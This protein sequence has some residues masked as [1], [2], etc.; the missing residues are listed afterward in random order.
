MLLWSIAIV[1]AK[2]FKETGMGEEAQVRSVP[3]FVF[4]HAYI[5]VVILPFGLM[6]GVRSTQCICAGV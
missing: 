3:V 5:F 1:C 2:E 4:P 6:G